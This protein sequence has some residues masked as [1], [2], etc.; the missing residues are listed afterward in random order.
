MVKKDWVSKSGATTNIIN[1]ILYSLYI[2]V[3]TLN[4]KFMPKTFFNFKPT[5][6]GPS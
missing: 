4:A 1:N 6:Q 2:L 3:C 5:G